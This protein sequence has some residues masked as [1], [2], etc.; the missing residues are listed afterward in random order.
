[1]FAGTW[2]ATCTY[3]SFLASDSPV[4]CV[5]LSSFYN[6]E[7]TSCPMCSC[8]CR[9][10]TDKKMEKCIRF[11]V[12][13]FYCIIPLRDPNL[14]V[15]LNST[16]PSFLYLFPLYDNRQA[17]PL[18]TSV[19]NDGDGLDT[20]KCTN[21]MCPI[22]VHWHVKTNYL[23][24]WRVKLTITNYNY[25]KNFSNWNV[26][27]QH[28]GL[29]KEARTYSFNSTILPTGFRGTYSIWYFCFNNHES[30]TKKCWTS[31]WFYRLILVERMS[32]S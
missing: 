14:Q 9:P 18:G 7:I 2:K 32:V 31:S 24:H 25:M 22:R 3:S 17:Y 4:C 16:N 20:V 23:T 28:P 15:N 1:M 6:S 26:L 8:G 10:V 19:E 11:T 5:S 13:Y 21:H 12:N 30:K 29:S 27:V